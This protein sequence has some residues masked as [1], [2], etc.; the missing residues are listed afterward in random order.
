MSFANP[1]MLYFLISIP[2]LAIWFFLKKKKQ[3]V[4]IQLSSLS[5][6]GN[7]KPNLKVR[8]RNVP[9][10]FR[11]IALALIIVALARPQSKTS[12][13]D[14]KTEGIDIVIAFDISASMLAKDFKPDRLEAAKEV[15][16][17]F[18]DK[19]PNDRIGL[20]IFSGESFTQCPL[21]SDH[22]IL[23]NLFKDV[24]TGMVQDGTAIGM[25]LA[26]AVNRIKD[27][28]AKSKVIIL[29]TDGVNNSGSV[30][31]ELAAEIA[32][33]FGIRVYTIGVGTTGM[34]LSPVALYPNGQYA[35]D[36]V[37]VKIDE[38][39][40][41]KISELTNGKYFR[42]TNKQKLEEIYKEIDT[43][44]KSIIEEKQYTKKNEMFLPFAAAAFLFLV[45]EFILKNT[46]LKTVN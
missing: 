35:Y 18:I 13:Q 28:K 38:D 12:W 14:I 41:R 26:T 23:K 30:S 36:Y 27:S 39:V 22:N 5:V 9:F 19:R 21:T 33:P 6:L 3:V 40:M 16:I 42:A 31:P 8:L 44:E 20:V 34:A 17:S 46:W 25:G 7:V 11:L 4:S 45:L 37:E 29:L 10:L 15:A 43:L 32:V 2:L 1:L 24:K